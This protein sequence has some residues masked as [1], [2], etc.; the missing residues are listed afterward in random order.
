MIIG[1][2]I[3]GCHLR[4]NPL[5]FDLLRHMGAITPGGNFGLKRCLKDSDNP[6][7]EITD[8]VIENLVNS[9][10]RIYGHCLLQGNFDIPRWRELAN[11]EFEF[12]LKSALQQ[13]C[14]RY[15]GVISEWEFL[16]EVVSPRGGLSNSVLRDRL[17]ANFP[18]NI[19]QWIREIDP[20]VPLYYSEYGLE[21]LDKLD[22]TLRF[23]ENLLNSGCNLTGVAIQF[24]HNTKGAIILSGIERA[25]TKFKSLGLKAKLSE[26]TI[27]RDAVGLGTL[28]A[29]AQAEAYGR[30][31]EM[32]I[33]ANCESFTFWCPV[34]LYSWKLAERC[35]G[36]WDKDFKESLVFEKI[37]KIAQKYS[38]PF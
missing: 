23:C 34:D 11:H 24:H 8:W 25:I 15:Q 3:A 5:A 18:L 1:G 26:V 16:G 13:V 28:S 9:P 32:A 27:W 36:L 6:D 29:L 21:S 38:L 4:A 10:I 31:F 33:A 19:Y 2:Q 30:L 12:K 22:A 7:L 35:P 37:S 17:G 14:D 20:V